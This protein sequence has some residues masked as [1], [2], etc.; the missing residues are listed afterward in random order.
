MELDTCSDDE[1][2]ASYQRQGSST[3]DAKVA[4]A[5][6]A[7]QRQS[8][9]GDPPVFT[10]DDERAELATLTIDEIVDIEKDLRG[11][12]ALTT[13]LGELGLDDSGRTSDGDDGEK[14]KKRKKRTKKSKAEEV[15]EAAGHITVVATDDDIGRLDL[16]LLQL[17]PSLK[18]AFDQAVIKCPE[19]LSREHKAAFLEREGLNAHVAA[20]R[21]VSYW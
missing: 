7:F 20:L 15:A 8:A 6:A 12:A 19:L 17:N 10:E 13:G 1:S 11:V 9:E 5:A 21:M 16:E 4:A 3:S 2:L 14:T 18:V